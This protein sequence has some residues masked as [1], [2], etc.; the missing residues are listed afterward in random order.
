MTFQCILDFGL[1][2][3]LFGSP[4][5]RLLVVAGSYTPQDRSHGPVTTLTP[6]VCERLLK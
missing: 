1:F 4:R 6:A 5:I 3:L 2:L